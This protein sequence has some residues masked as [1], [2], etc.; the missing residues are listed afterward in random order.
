L[1]GLTTQVVIGLAVLVVLG[2]NWMP[3]LDQRAEEYLIDAMA[4]NLLIYATARSLNGIIS[5]VQSIEL[6]VSLGAGVAVNLGEILDPLNDLVERFSA[7]VLYGLAGLGLQKL[8]LIATSGLVMK[9]VTTVGLVLGY[10][11]YLLRAKLHNWLVRLVV[12]VLMVRFAFIV[13]VGVIATLD[14]LY[15]DQQKDEAHSALQLAK[16]S[17]G[18]LREEYMAAISE[19]GLYGGLWET[20]A[21]IVGSDEQEGVANIAASAVVELIV[22]TLVRGLI[23]PLAFVWMLVV[24]GRLLL[25]PRGK[26]EQ[27]IP[28]MEVR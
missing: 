26:T 24:A 11:A 19:S 16:T 5:V 27:Q 14:S 15:F 10:V 22:I 3:G 2:L 6:S 17:L 28:D 18:Q 21:T 4:D 12:L 13:E 23:L 25:N 1:R 20:V 7:F 9:V 8:V